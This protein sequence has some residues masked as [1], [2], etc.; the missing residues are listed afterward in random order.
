[1]LRVICTRLRTD[2]LNV[3]VGDGSRRSEEIVKNLSICT[4]QCETA[5][6][7]YRLRRPPRGRKIPGSNP[8]CDGIFPGLSHSSD[9]KIGTSVATL[10][11]DWR[12]W[13]S[14]GT[15]WPGVSIL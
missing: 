10:S 7:A 15:G 5:S 8:V 2:H 9:L 6:L 3:R 11:G 14:A 13:V 1:M 12:Y 4:F